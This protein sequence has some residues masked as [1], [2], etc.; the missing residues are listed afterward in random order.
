[1]LLRCPRSST[2]AAIAN[3][4]APRP[5]A[6]HLTTSTLPRP[7]PAMAPAVPRLRILS[8]AFR[9]APAL[10][11]AL[12]P[13][14]SARLPGAAE[15]T[16]AWPGPLLTAASWRKRR[17]CIPLVAVT[18]DQR[19]R[20][21]ARVEV[22]IRERCTIRHLFQVKLTV[23]QCLNPLTLTTLPDLHSTATNASSPML[24]SSYCF[25]CR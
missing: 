14:G 24:V 6:H 23:S 25:F 13:R 4:L 17:F 5:P 15:Q 19:L 12:Q 1:M 22:G 10:F 9:P 21:H 3:F 16:P 18:S 8:G 20:R 11:S 2:T 7:P